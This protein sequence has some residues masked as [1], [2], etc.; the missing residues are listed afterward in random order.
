[1]RARLRASLMAGA[2]AILRNT[3]LLKLADAI[4]VPTARRTASAHHAVDGW[5]DEG[6]R[7]AGL[8]AI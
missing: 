4:A 8:Y 1:M 6:Q 3:G 5:A 2:V 7:R